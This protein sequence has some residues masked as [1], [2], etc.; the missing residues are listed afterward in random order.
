VTQ[1]I[2]GLHPG[3]DRHPALARDVKIKD[4][5]ACL[6]LAVSVEIQ[7]HDPTPTSHNEPRGNRRRPQD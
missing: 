6:L 4:V 5:P 7:D 2:A 1:D 3:A